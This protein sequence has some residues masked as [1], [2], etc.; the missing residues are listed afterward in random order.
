MRVRVASTGVASALGLDRDEHWSGLV[1]GR[2]ALAG[3]PPAARIDRERAR[4]ELRRRSSELARAA[5]RSGDAFEAWLLGLVL[6][7]ARVAPGALVV[8]GTTKGVPEPFLR[9]AG[10]VPLVVSQACASGTQ[11]FAIGA[12]LV[13]AGEVARVAVAG[14]EALGP[15]VEDGFASLMALDPRGAR[16][17]DRARGGLSLGEGA[18]CAVLDGTGPPPI[19]PPL[20]G[21]GSGGGPSLFIV[22]AGSASDA[23]SSTSP[24]PQ[25]RGLERALRLA[26]AGASGPP[27]F[28]CA[29]GTGTEKNDPAELAALE[30]VAPTARVFSI[31]G[32][33][34]HALG[35]AG[36]LDAVTALLALERGEIP[37]TCD[38]P[39]ADCVTRGAEPIAGARVALSANAGFGGL[40]A[41]LAFEVLP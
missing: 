18:A 41:A 9:E 11:A 15:F 26:L 17:F 19:P 16:P 38:D 5:E 12:D 28:V 37:G 13:E 7:E 40:D 22:G 39:L 3:T 20:R 25:G 23:V 34:G 27:A 24:D 33:V 31:K 35:G 4:A 8:V 2:S 21:G 1:G 32:R 6:A 10:F 14:V 36:A 29:H 30:R